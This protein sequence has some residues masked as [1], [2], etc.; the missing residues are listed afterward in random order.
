M[1]NFKNDTNNNNTAKAIF[2]NRVSDGI[3]YLVQRHGYSQSRATNLILNELRKSDPLPSDDEIFQTMQKLQL[4]MDE[5]TK[6]IIISNAFSKLINQN[7]LSPSKAMDQ[8]TSNLTTMKLLNK[9]ESQG[10]KRIYTSNNSNN[11]STK[12][13][14]AASWQSLQN[15]SD[16]SNIASS[17]AMTNKELISSPN[18]N[19]KKANFVQKSIAKT[20]K[21]MEQEEMSMETQKQQQQQLTNDHNH[22]SNPESDAVDV[23]VVQKVIL[24]KSVDNSNSN[25]T[26]HPSS[27]S[28]SSSST[29]TTTSP[30]VTSTRK[31]TGSPRLSRG[32]R[33]LQQVVENDPQ[34]PTKRR[35]LDSI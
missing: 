33:D 28:T 35:R 6:V 32:K 34:Q 4:G 27:S 30:V 9:I 19:R 24:Q 12:I 1:G 5:A 11:K 14:K 29:T 3:S 26:D 2:L 21:K 13:Q 31:R 25:S 10:Q 23:A 18:N 15:V 8:L 22:S 16:K 17:I 7:K 20:P